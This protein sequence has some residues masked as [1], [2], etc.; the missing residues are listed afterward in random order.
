MPPMPALTKAE[1]DRAIAYH[2]LA[3]TLRELES[4]LR[5][6]LND[7]L[8]IPT[9]WGELLREPSVP[10]KRKLTLRLDEDVIAFFRAMGVGHLTRMNRVLRA[11]MLTRL[12]GVASGPEMVGYRP[13][14][15]E[16]ERSLLSQVADLIAKEIAARE[17]AEAAASDAA[18]RRHRIAYLKQKLAEKRGR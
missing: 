2:G 8:R 10:Q 6:G 16:E 1:R 14:A 18:K 15:K 3:C 7:S 17:A 13:T 9:G 5:W 4:D 11:F 12:A